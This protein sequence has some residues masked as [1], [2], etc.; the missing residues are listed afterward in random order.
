M[1][2]RRCASAL[3]LAILIAG[4]G[5]DE[6]QDIDTK[7]DA[8]SRCRMSIERLDHAGQLV[9]VDG[10]V[11]KYDSLG[12]LA[13]DYHEAVAAGKS[14]REAWV[15]EYRTGHWLKAEAAYFALAGLASDHMG[16]GVAAT[17]SQA[18]AEKLAAGAK[19]VRWAEL[20]T[21]VLAIEKGRQ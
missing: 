10:R 14:P 18:D 21:A 7:A 11:R 15:A 5:A 13:L 12:C 8:C 1:R 9:S 16:Y 6:P 2:P 4:C 19:V 17:S 3:A 20:P